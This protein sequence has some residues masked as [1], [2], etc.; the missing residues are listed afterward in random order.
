MASRVKRELRREKIENMRVRGTLEGSRVLSSRRSTIEDPTKYNLNSTYMSTFQQSDGI[1][2]LN[3]NN[4]VFKLSQILMK[5][6]QKQKAAGNCDL[7][8]VKQ[9]IRN[10][11]QDTP[12]TE[13]PLPLKYIKMMTGLDLV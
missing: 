12:P 9:R 3:N 8:L 10:M 5:P 6:V 11:Q 1:E 13:K 7:K 2:R 4:A